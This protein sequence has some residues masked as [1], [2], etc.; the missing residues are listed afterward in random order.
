MHPV[1]LNGSLVDAADA[2]VLVSDHG[3][4]VGDG[5]FETMRTERGVPFAATR[6]LRRLRHSLGGLGLALDRSDDELRGGLQ[7]VADAV[8][9]AT[10]GPAKI[11]LTVTAGPGPLGSGRDD[12]GHTVI[13]AGAALDAWPPTGTAVTVPWRRNEHSAVAGL[14]TTSY[15]ENVVAL[16]SARDAGASEAILANT[17]GELCEGTGSNVFVVH[18]ATVRTPPLT[19]GCLA[20]VTRALVVELAGRHGIDLREE[21]ISMDALTTA[22][23]VFLTSSTRDVHPQ[24]RVDDRAF[25][26][27]GPLTRTLRDAFAAMAAD[28]VDP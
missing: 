10:G 4:T 27:P 1:W 12:D 17:A 5:V 8:V 15:A 6:H 18:G 16:A 19:S 25:D 14:K 23:E 2:S 9:S 28:D 24:H 26:A 3:L 11:R 20:G 7:A 13:V 22:D 21:P